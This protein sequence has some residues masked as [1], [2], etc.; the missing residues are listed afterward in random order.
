MF[1]SWWEGKPAQSLWKS[2]WTTLRQVRI[3]LPYDPATQLLGI[4]KKENKSALELILMLQILLSFF[5]LNSVN[6]IIL[7]VFIY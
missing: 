3:D 4:Y 5:M 7:I 1:H 2:V 6:A